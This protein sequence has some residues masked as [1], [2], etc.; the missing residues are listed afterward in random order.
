MK[1]EHVEKNYDGYRSLPDD[2]LTGSLRMKE[3]QQVSAVISKYI[4]EIHQAEPER[5]SK[6]EWTLKEV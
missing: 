1:N 5:H 6:R 3:K 2:I 4:R